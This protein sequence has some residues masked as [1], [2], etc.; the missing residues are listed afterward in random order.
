MNLRKHIS[1]LLLPLFCLFGLSAIAQMKIQKTLNLKWNFVQEDSSIWRTAQVPGAVHLDL[2]REGVIKDPFIG[3]G[4]KDCKWVADKN[5]I[6]QSAPFDFTADMLSREVVL[7]RFNGLDTYAK[8][9][10]NDKEILS[11]NNAFRSWE[12]NVKSVIKEQ[13]NILR[14]V[15][16]SPL[17]ESKKLLKELPYPLPG[18][19]FRAVTRKPQFHYGWD[20]GPE[21]VSCGISKNIE[22]IA[23]STSV[24]KNVAY[25]FENISKESVTVKPHI[26]LYNQTAQAAN[27]RITCKETEAVL[28]LPVQLEK[29]EQQIDASFSIEWP[30]LWW[31]NG[32]GDPNLYTFSVELEID[33]QINDRLTT[34]TGIRSIEL[35]TEKDS[36]GETFYFKL[37]GIPVFMR[38]ANFIPMTYFPGQANADDYARLLRSCRE[39]NFNM[40]RV[41]GGGVYEDEAFYQSC[42]E[43]GI[44][45]W[46][47]F[48]FACSMYPGNKDF[49]ANLDAE[50]TEQTIRLRN[51]P[52]MA[53]WC[54][55]N[56]N[57]EAWLNW[58]WQYNLDPKQKEKIWQ[59][60]Q[61]VF[62]K[63]LRP[64]V[65]KYAHI[66]YVSTSPRYGRGDKRSMTE[67]DA[68]Y[69]GLWHDAEN[70]EALK[71]KIPRFMSEFGMQAYPS[72]P[73]L[74]EIQGS[75]K[76]QA[77]SAGFLQHQKHSRGFEL[78]DT[79]M[80][81]WY[82]AVNT[83]NIAEYATMTQAV[84]AE[85]IIMGIEAQRRSNG[86]CMGTLY[87]QLND[88]WPSFSWS[89]IDYKG[90]PKLLFYGLKEAYAPQLI[91][92]DVSGAGT[93][94]LHWISDYIDPAGKAKLVI[95]YFDADNKLMAADSLE[96]IELN[97]GV[98][99]IYSKD[100]RQLLQRKE[101]SDVY[102]EVALYDELNQVI[103]QRTKKLVPQSKYYLIPH[104]QNG[105]MTVKKL[106]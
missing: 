68:H 25:E 7:L 99:L 85:G 47:D 4:E 34:R 74:E 62:E 50:A 3:T 44:M 48:M 67:G 98:Q 90:N 64:I 31:C 69:W 14:I 21:L 66:P 101:L 6:Y 100:V 9:F 84:Q 46:Q 102:I 22:F 37:N 81:K 65:E 13:G 63:T 1:A 59:A 61:D 26:T 49:L 92:P 20:W 28:S 73:V 77:G 57:E 78:M 11:A 40:L 79:Y 15:F 86:R 70:F 93:V 72:A 54:G 82:P 45:I 19:D 96:N 91:S 43:Q 75:E 87:W 41:W 80:K 53:L 2:V 35:V 94:N 24:I 56:E 16:R 89:S 36:I 27:L 30:K 29:G 38:G 42:D 71:V 32:L 104:Y 8:V 97:K 12:V 106:R 105:R 10:L 83:S 51:H 5:W 39:Q 23:Y 76:V 52:C 60:Y 95:R 88:V 55:N 58:G 17:L 33:N 103:S 18:Y